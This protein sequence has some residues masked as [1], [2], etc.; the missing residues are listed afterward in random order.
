M[1]EAE[2]AEELRRR[3][4]RFLG[5]RR[6]LVDYYRI[7]RRVSFPWPVEKLP[8]VGFA[9]GFK[10]YPWDIW[11]S[12]EAEERI[13]A[14]GW[15]GEIGGDKEVRAKVKEELLSVARWPRHF[16][17]QPSARPGLGMAHLLRMMIL[18]KRQWRWLDEAGDEILAAC[19]RALDQKRAWVERDVMKHQTRASIEKLGVYESTQVT[20]NIPVIS[21]LVMVM[22]AEEV[23]HESLAVLQNHLLA[24]L[25]VRLDLAVNG[26]TEGIAYDGYVLDFMADWLA[27]P[28]VPAE[29]FAEFS[30]HAAVGQQLAMPA[31]LAAPGD[32][33]NV[34]NLADVEPREMT[35]YATGAARMGQMLG[36]D[37]VTGWLLGRCRLDWLRAQCL[38]VMHRLKAGD[39][40][41]GSGARSGAYTCSLRSGYEAQDVAVVMGA[42]RSLMHHLHHDAGSIVI[43]HRGVWLVADPGYQQYL[44]TKEREFTIGPRAHNAPVVNG[45]A[46][47]KH[48]GR[49]LAAEG[50]G[51]NGQKM[52]I[53][54]SACYEGLAGK[55]IRTVWLLARRTAVVCD[56]MEGDVEKVG[57][58][59]HGLAEAGWWAQ[60]GSALIEHEG[61]R[62]WISS[63]SVEILQGQIQRLPGSRGQQSLVVNVAGGKGRTRCWWIF[64]LGQESSRYE[65]RGAGIVVEGVEFAEPSI[66]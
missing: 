27:T 47:S 17:G 55:V 25:R 63:P 45:I 48:G 56:V 10:N 1:R 16:S 60:G 49:I 43:G 28:G 11:F 13:D 65:R 42:G 20:A 46:Q 18:A 15:W 29:L 24:M 61:A 5:Q 8:E 62:V 2:I 32:I 51:A 38:G 3:G 66:P 37:E 9:V 54:L 23:K 40:K 64:S 21:A 12:W 50:T 53:D 36:S 52:E 31:D 57:Y 34:A 7:R 39:A 22:A 59:W 30:K 4:E 33:L 6:L 19:A 14:L 26:M 41:P 44:A 35:F 58:A